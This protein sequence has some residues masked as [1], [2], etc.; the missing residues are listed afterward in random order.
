LASSTLP[1]RA[2]AAPG[3]RCNRTSGVLPIVDS[4]VAMSAMDAFK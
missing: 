4:T 1:R 2:A 3:S